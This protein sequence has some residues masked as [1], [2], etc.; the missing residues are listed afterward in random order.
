[1]RI[2]MKVRF[3]IGWGIERECGCTTAIREFWKFFFFVHLHMQ[4]MKNGKE[5]N[6]RICV[7]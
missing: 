5:K 3:K 4:K 1:M 2:I 7:E 6:C